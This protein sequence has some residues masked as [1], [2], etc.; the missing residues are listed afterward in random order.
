[1]SPATKKFFNGLNKLTVASAL[2]FGL[3]GVDGSTAIASPAFVATIGTQT[4]TQAHSPVVLAAYAFTSNPGDVREL[5][6]QIEVTY[7]TR[8]TA[9]TL[10]LDCWHSSDPALLTN[11][12]A[13]VFS[14]TNTQSFNT[15]TNP[16]FIVDRFLFQA[17]TTDLPGT[18]YTCKLL[19]RAA[20]FDG[21]SDGLFNIV[22][23]SNPNEFE[24]VSGVIGSNVG[25][26]MFGRQ[27]IVQ[28]NNQSDEYIAGGQPLQSY[29]AVS[30]YTPPPSPTTQTIEAVSDFYVTDCKDTDDTGAG[31]CKALGTAKYTTVEYRLVL[32]SACGTVQ[33]PP[34]G[35]STKDVDRLSNGTLVN[36]HHLKIGL[37]VTASVPTSC[38]T[39]QWTATLKLGSGSGTDPYAINW[40]GGSPVGGYTVT[41]IRPCTTDCG[42]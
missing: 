1:M 15:S 41:F 6:G 36:Q 24:D 40:P 27:V 33:S 10:E 37:S 2:I 7:N 32:T 22:T 17:P 39:D 18:S 14:G 16:A 28:G 31:Y 9:V 12:L 13:F 29:A 3:V 30:G 5:R 19:G 34:S 42:I 25:T 38:A 26:T 35:F 23:A 20:S 21:L 8:Q 11:R 4:V